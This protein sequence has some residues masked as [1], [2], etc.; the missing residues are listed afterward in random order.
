MLPGVLNLTFGKGGGEGGQDLYKLERTLLKLKASWIP[1]TG[2]K[3]AS[4]RLSS[5]I[6]Q[7]R[8]SCLTMRSPEFDKVPSGLGTS[9]PLSP[10]RMD[11]TRIPRMVQ[12][13]P[14]KNWRK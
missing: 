12:I 14:E 1:G 4:L 10:H 2:Q 11:T 9:A 13:E 8:G 3:N 7:C 5:H 6:E